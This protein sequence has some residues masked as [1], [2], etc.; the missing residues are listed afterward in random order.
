VNALMRALHGFGRAIGFTWIGP[1]WR[2]CRVLKRRQRDEERERSERDRRRAPYPCVPINRPELLRPDPLIYSQ[3]FLM[4]HGLAVTW[5]NPDIVL[6]KGGG[7]VPSSSLEPATEYE[8][9]AR[10]WNASPSCPVVSLP[11]HFSFLSFG[12]GTVSTPI[13]KTHVD[14]GVKGGPGCP[15][16]ASILWRTPSTPGHYC[17][18]V[19]LTPADELNFDNNVGQENT[20]VGIAHSSA[21]FEFQ[22]RNPTEL[23]QT[24]RFTT[25]AYSIPELEPCAPPPDTPRRPRLLRLDVRKEGFRRRPTVDQARIARHAVASHPLPPG[26]SV[27]LTPRT[28]NVLPQEEITIA[29]KVSPPDDFRGSLGVNVNAFTAA[30]F[31][32][33]ITLTVVRE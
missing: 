8:I 13:G 22:L 26:W 7:V 14:L 12:V 21:E 30:R 25:D 28:P 15:A 23:E 31:A 6:M 19:R 20:E 33:G 10:I 4:Q 5:D 18:Q 16:F 11:V 29:V 3:S 27:E 1:L 24:Y 32:G 2:L 9:V 17:I